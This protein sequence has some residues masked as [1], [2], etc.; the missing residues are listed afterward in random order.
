V[1]A[2]AGTAA[3]EGAEVVPLRR[4][5]DERGAVFQM[6]KATDPHFAG[7]GEV[8]FSSVYPGVVKGWKRHRRMTANYACI[9]GLVRVVLYDDRGDS[10]TRGGLMD[11]RIGPDEYALVVIPPNVWHGFQ[12]LSHPA[13]ILA[14]CATEPS[15]PDELD[16]LDPDDPRIPYEWN[17]EGR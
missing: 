3:L 5:T 8:Y 17:G 16:R 13:A 11:L 14:N 2:P 6:L 4:Y 7:F 12:G 1:S 15:D 9:F 10:S